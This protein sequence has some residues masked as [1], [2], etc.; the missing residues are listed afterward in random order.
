MWSFQPNHVVIL[1]SRLHLKNIFKLTY[2]HAVGSNI[3]LAVS[4]RNLYF[5]IKTIFFHSF[6]QDILRLQAILSVT[7]QK[8]S[9]HETKKDFEI[10][11]NDRWQLIDRQ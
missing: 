7:S 6:S 3:H 2:S 10:P 11:L 8:E 1:L 9:R 4:S 5:H